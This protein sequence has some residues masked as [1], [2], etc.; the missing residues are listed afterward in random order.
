[1]KNF[2]HPSMARPGRCLLYN[3]QNGRN[4]FL[5]DQVDSAAAITLCLLGGSKWAAP[6]TTKNEQINVAGDHLLC[7]SHPCTDFHG[8]LQCYFPTAKNMSGS[9]LC[10]AFLGEKIK[11]KPKIKGENNYFK[12]HLSLQ[13]PLKTVCH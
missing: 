13:F 6:L 12:S 3:M 11:T 1:M 5:H 7:N 8:K 9:V 10:A 4:M 2:S